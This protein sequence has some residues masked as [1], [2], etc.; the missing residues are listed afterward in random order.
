M[1]SLP[2]SAFLEGLNAVGD[3]KRAQLLQDGLMHNLQQQWPLS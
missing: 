3:G 1:S 2:L